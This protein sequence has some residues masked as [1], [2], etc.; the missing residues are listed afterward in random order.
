M[1]SPVNNEQTLLK[2]SFSAC[3]DGFIAIAT[4]SLFINLLILT[5]P[6]YMMQ[7]FDRVLMSRSGETLF[8]LTAIA[9]AALA[10]MA[11]LEVVR[12]SLMIHLSNWLDKRLGGATLSASVHMS[13]RL[14]K[15]PGIQGLRD[16]A[17]LRAFLTGP[18]VFPILDAPWTPIFIGVIFMLHPLLGWV[19]LIGAILLF[20]LAMANEF[21][22]RE[23]LQRATGASMEAM[24]QAE[25]SARNAAAI[26]AMGMMPNII[27]RWNEKNDQ[28]LELQ[29]RAS[30]ISGAITASSKFARM[31]LQIGI[32]GT[33]A[34]LVIQNEMLAGGMIAAS[35][36]MGRALAP[37]EQAIGT[38]KNFVGSRNAYYRIEALLEHTP[39]RGGAMSLPRPK[40]K[41]IAEKVVFRYPGTKEPVLRGISFQLDP[42]DILGL[43]G[44][45][46]AG[47]TTLAQLIVGN[48]E[49][50][51]GSVRLDNADIAKWES[52]DRG[53]YIGYLPQ[54]VE[55]FSGK[56]RDNIAR[57]A[58]GDTKSVVESA[59]LAGIH[60][61]VLDLPEGY[62][63]EIGHQGS[64]LSG[65]Q[66]Q[67]VA[68]ARAV[69]GNPCLLVLDEPNASLDVDGEA[70]LLKMIQALKKRGIT[71]IIIA[72]RPNIM[73]H[74]DKI[75]VLRDG[76]MQAFGPRDEI[77]ARLKGEV[78]NP[79]QKNTSTGAS[80]SST[81][82]D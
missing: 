31:V 28:S 53:R 70:A 50:N 41:V 56:V 20:G 38:W 68:L 72:H 11:G 46:A 65:G 23:L 22:T 10:V 66:R 35:I 33:G 30:S 14:E 58:D 82:H 64:I 8:M 9:I 17:T 2:E 45:S 63:T 77:L 81:A 4:F 3:R 80:K 71:I 61:M 25:S 52:D 79:E 60:E 74:V 43:V 48:L 75:L 7:V 5:A 29:A 44:P 15:D 69:Y 55:L 73:Q 12:T 67:R 49:P 27:R 36:L 19:S 1:N 18:G 39:A 40:G 59:R 78:A 76:A 6:L 16:L 26:E 62:E 47:K 34:W 57:M 37:V 32:M 51:A 24:A 21:S 54:D 42:G 13:L